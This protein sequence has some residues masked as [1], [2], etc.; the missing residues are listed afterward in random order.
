MKYQGRTT[1][2]WKVRVQNPRRLKVYDTCGFKDNLSEF[3]KSFRAKKRRGGMAER[4]A[5]NTI[6]GDSIE[7]V[8][9]IA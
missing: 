6:V 7:M 8:E 5:R 2:I 4:D 9:K 3:W 1:E